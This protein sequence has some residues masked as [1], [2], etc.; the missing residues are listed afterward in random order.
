MS[1]ILDL[2]SAVSPELVLNDGQKRAIE[3]LQKICDRQHHT[4]PRAEYYKNASTILIKT[5]KLT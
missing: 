1:A 5:L 4:V 2:Y 3:L